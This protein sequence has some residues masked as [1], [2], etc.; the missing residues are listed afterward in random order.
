MEVNVEVNDW[1]DEGVHSVV[2]RVVGSFSSSSSFSLF[3]FQ[4]D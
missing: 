3:F 2:S 4:R 1:V